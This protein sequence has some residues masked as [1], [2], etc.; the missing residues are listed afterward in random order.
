MSGV[1]FL[2]NTLASANLPSPLFTDGQSR[3]DLVRTTFGWVESTTNKAPRTFACR[4]DHTIYFLLK[5]LFLGHGKTFSD[6][7]FGGCGSGCGPVT[8][9]YGVYASETIWSATKYAT[10][11]QW[12]FGTPA[13]RGG[14][15]TMFAPSNV[16]F[17]IDAIYAKVGTITA[18]TLLSMSTSSGFNSQFWLPCQND[19]GCTSGLLSKCPESNIECNSAHFSEPNGVFNMLV[20]AA[21]FFFRYTAYKTSLATYTTYLGFLSTIGA[22]PVG[23]SVSDGCSPS[24]FTSEVRYQVTDPG[25]GPAYLVGPTYASFNNWTF[26]RGRIPASRLADVSGGGSTAASGWPTICQ[27]CYYVGECVSAPPFDFEHYSAVLF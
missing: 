21:A 11:G 5:N 7:P 1:Y 9:A 4:S 19:S 16:G 12:Y 18:S 20:E 8:T 17:A 13:R 6:L 3:S 25:D 10:Y 22:L 26:Y 24:E 23:M 27:T 2:E 14:F 15:Q